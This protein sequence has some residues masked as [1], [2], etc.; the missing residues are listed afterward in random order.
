[1]E[2]LAIK[3]ALRIMFQEWKQ[4]NS[5]ASFHYA[6]ALRKSKV[7][8]I[9][10]NNISDGSQTALKIGRSLNI[11]KWKEYPYLHAECDVISQ[12]K[13]KYHPKEIIII[14]LRINR[15]GQF[16]LAKPCQHCQKVLD[17]L[18]YYNVW[19]SLTNEDKS[20]NLILSNNIESIN[21]KHG[22]L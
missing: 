5:R 4:D 21:F 15:I 1:M 16:R 18:G 14:S 13:D 9:G 19:W 3:R 17:I 20:G 2:E 8:A 7:I 11:N 12:I 22:K 6:F 10:K